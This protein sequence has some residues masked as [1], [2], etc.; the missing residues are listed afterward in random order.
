MSPTDAVQAIGF[1]GTSEVTPEMLIAKYGK[2]AHGE[3]PQDMQLSLA[4]LES[5]MYLRNQLLRDSDWASMHHS[6]ELRTPLVDA[7]LLKNLQPYLNAFP[8]FPKKS[9]L[10]NSPNKPLPSMLRSRAKTGFSIPVYQW[11]Q[12]VTSE[13]R[14]PKAAAWAKFVA[15]RY[16]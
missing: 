11:M 3:F 14:G 7:Q 12:E 16:Q 2:A 13:S 10:A 5:T 4:Q 6:V 9:L 1:P 8:R 15:S